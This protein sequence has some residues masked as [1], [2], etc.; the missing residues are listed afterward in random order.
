MHEPN[1]FVKCDCKD[2]KEYNWGHYTDN[3]LKATRDL[4][5]RAMNE[6][7]FLE[8]NVYRNNSNVYNLFATVKYGNNMAVI[9]F[10]SRDLSSILSSI[11]IRLSPNQIYLSSNY[12]IEVSLHPSEN[13]MIEALQFL[14]QDNTSLHM[15]NE[16]SRAVFHSDY[17]IYDRVNENLKAGSYHN[18]KELINE[19]KGYT[20]YLKGKER[21]NE[22]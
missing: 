7:K 14:F 12:G 17:R 16:V 6:L 4:C 8:S 21:S 3:S 18:L 5:E 11:G 19:V 15:V 22:R 9:E 2:G 13:K 20:Q 10:P 1:Q